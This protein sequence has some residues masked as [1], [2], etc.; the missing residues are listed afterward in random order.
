MQGGSWAVVSSCLS[1]PSFPQIARSVAPSRLRTLPPTRRRTHAPSLSLLLISVFLLFSSPSRRA[2]H[3]TTPVLLLSA[4]TSP[5]PLR[6]SSVLQSASLFALAAAQQPAGGSGGGDAPGAFEDSFIFIPD[7]VDDEFEFDF[8]PPEAVKP[9]EAAGRGP[10]GSPPG[11]ASFAEHLLELPV[12]FW[13]ALVSDASADARRQSDAERGEEALPPQAPR[14]RR[15]QSTN[16]DAK[17]ERIVRGPASA[18]KRVAA[19]RL[20]RRREERSS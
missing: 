13:A 12:S 4:H 2:R 18:K 17:G 3:A 14:Q 7:D 5:L 9:G 1:S 19:P 16:A 15:L 6:L 10:P 11:S 20:D 8:Y